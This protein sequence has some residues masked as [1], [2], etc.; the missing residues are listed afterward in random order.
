MKKTKFLTYDL[1]PDLFNTVKPS[2]AFSQLKMNLFF[3]HIYIYINLF[4]MGYL[5]C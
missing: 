4:S 2:Q 5:K 3:C 1:N